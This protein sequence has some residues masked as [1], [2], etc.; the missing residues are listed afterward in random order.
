MNIYESML[1]AE[2]TLNHRMLLVN[3]PR[4]MIFAG[5]GAPVSEAFDHCAWAA[6]DADVE[7]KPKGIFRG[8]HHE[9]WE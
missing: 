8:F 4:L 5:P 1:D 9:Q 7:R 3:S 2:I 6:W